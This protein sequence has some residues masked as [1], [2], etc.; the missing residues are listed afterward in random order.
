MI[1]YK[2][3]YK[4]LKEGATEVLD[5]LKQSNLES[6]EKVHKTYEILNKIIN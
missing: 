6:K 4:E 5:I 2:E 3:K 1:D